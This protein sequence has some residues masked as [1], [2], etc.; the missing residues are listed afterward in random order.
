[1]DRA[2]GSTLPDQLEARD[3]DRLARQI[4]VGKHAFLL[5]GMARLGFA[6]IALARGQRRGVLLP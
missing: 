4:D 5:R 2:D 6:Q 1:M 3:L